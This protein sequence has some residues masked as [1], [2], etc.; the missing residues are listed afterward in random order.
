MSNNTG[1]SDLIQKITELTDPEEDNM[2]FFPGAGDDE[3]LQFERDNNFTLPEQVKEW[4]RFTDGCCL[5]DTTIQ[6]Y[7]VAHK[8]IIDTSPKGVTE[9]YVRIGG[10]NFGDLVCISKNSP[11]IIQYG[12]TQIEYEDFREFL[13]HVIEI[14]MDD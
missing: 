5:F 12:E 9:D 8:P 6:L 7:G 13:E 11:K 4:L 14:G 2:E 10:F 3:I 1:L